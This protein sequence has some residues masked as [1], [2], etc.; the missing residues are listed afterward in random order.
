MLPVLRPSSEPIGHFNQLRSIGGLHS[1]DD[2]FNRRNDRIGVGRGIDS[3]F[4]HDGRHAGNLL[5]ELVAPFACTL[6]FTRRLIELL[7]CIEGGLEHAIASLLF[8]ANLL[9]Q[10]AHLACQG[11]IDGLRRGDRR[12]VIALVLLKAIELGLNLRV[13]GGERLLLCFGLNCSL[14]LRIK[15]ALKF[16]D[17]A[18]VRAERAVPFRPWTV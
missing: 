10:V 1:A 14:F 18:I 15:L 4:P 12:D 17:V 8:V 7:G 16:L 5:R 11:L 9:P 13:V 2:A 3:F 6:V